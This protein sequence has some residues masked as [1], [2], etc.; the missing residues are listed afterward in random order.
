M[1]VI[2][3]NQ[4]ITSW[5]TKTKHNF[6]ETS[7]SDLFFP[8][9]LFSI[10]TWTVLFNGRHLLRQ[11]SSR[12]I[13]VAYFFFSCHQDLHCLYF[14]FT[15]LQWAGFCT[16]FQCE[17]WANMFAAFLQPSPVHLSSFWCFGNLQNHPVSLK[18][19][20]SLLIANSKSVLNIKSRKTSHV[21]IFKKT[22][23]QSYFRW[24]PC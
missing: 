12:H 5:Q 16:R 4:R 2:D 10:S 17:V 23:I 1:S 21:I 22:P 3:K 14:C 13:S 18:I 20:A 6:I 19:Y 11:Q 24:S 8:V 9:F 15:E 7:I